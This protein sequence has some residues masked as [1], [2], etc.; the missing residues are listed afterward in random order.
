MLA[1]P[2]LK[3]V[4]PS[5]PG[6]ANDIKK[7]G[8]EEHGYPRTPLQGRALDDDRAG[9]A[10]REDLPKV[11]QPLL[12]FLL[13]RGPR[14]RRR[15]PRGASARAVSS[16]DLTERMLENSY[17]VATLDNDAPTDLRGV[18]PVHPHE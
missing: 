6:I 18:R 5:F 8:V 11:T 12:M 4:V 17:H 10:V 9:G 16:R 3:H 14:R 1:L 15:R 7:P 2:V 13:R